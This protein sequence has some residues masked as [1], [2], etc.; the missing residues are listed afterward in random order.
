MSM[1]SIAYIKEKWTD[2]GFQKYFRNTGW[3]FSGR[4]FM[5]G[6]SFFVGIYIAR[7]LGPT[8][9]GLLNYVISFVGLFGFLASFGIDS[10][11]SRE[12]IKDADK[13]DSIIGTG[14]YIKVLGSFVAILAIFIISFFITKDIFTLGLI[15]LFSLNFIPQSFNILE[16]YFQSQVLSK[17]VVIAQVIS[18]IM[19]AILKILLIIFA[20]G[21][22]WLILVY[23]VETSIYAA[24]LLI[25]FKQFGT[26]IRHWKFD[27][28]IAVFLLKNSWP[29]MLSA[30]AIGIYMKIDQVMIKNMLGNEQSGIY[31]AAVKIAEIWYLI[32][33]LICISLFPTIIKAKNISSELLEQRLKKLYSLMFWMSF[34][35]AFLIAFFSKIIILTLFGV[36]YSGAIIV[37][38]IYVWAGISVFLGVAANQ[39]LIASNLTKI[40]FYITFLGAITNVILNLVLIPKIGIRGA[41]IATLISYTIATFGIF[42]FK[43]SRR[44]GVL[45]IKSIIPFYSIWVQKKTS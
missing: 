32:P 41:A 14:F 36:P 11:V 42:F 12:I 4:L 31:A 40:S 39:Y 1:L 25:S 43:E 3:L 20:K 2:A 24:I 22:F 17:R 15:C 27:R 28:K 29:L 21:I 38:Q 34:I 35:I 26:H 18:S 33:T 10:I 5:L 7:Y 13:K 9:Y 6:I 19:S 16:I 37:L 45:I 44:Q 23:I 30:V 8:N